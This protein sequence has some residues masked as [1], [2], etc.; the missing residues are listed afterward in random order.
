MTSASTSDTASGS[1]EGPF[2]ARELRELCTQGSFGNLYLTKQHP[3]TAKIAKELSTLSSVRQ[4]WLW[5]EITRTAM[6]HVI[7]LPDLEVVDVLRFRHPGALENFAGATEIKEFRCNGHMSEADLIEVSSL[8][9]LLEL[10]A[11]S[12]TVT[13]KA[14]DALLGIPKLSS[15]DLEDTALDDNMVAALAASTSIEKL[16]IGN[17]R[18]TAKGLRSLCTMTQLRELDIWSLDIQEEDLDILTELPKLEYLS[19]GSYFEPT[20]FTGKGVLPRL[21]KLPSLK[22]VWLDEI[23][24]SDSEKAD[25]EKRY[26][27]V[28]Y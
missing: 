16:E 6:R 22:R 24:L 3:I 9:N 14:I 25:L 19:I 1:L 17:T 2:G 15:L 28:Q 23:E 5:C 10:A 13:M 18:V 7:S 12:A 26:E 8:P 4:I 11:H 20:K 21:A 27:N